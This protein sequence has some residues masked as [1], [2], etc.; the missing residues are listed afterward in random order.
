M[1][2]SYKELYSICP[3]IDILSEAKFKSHGVIYLMGEISRHYMEFWV[4][5]D[6]YWLLLARFTVRIGSKKQ[7]RII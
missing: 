4:W 3:C 1:L 7:N 2:H 5:H 6:Y